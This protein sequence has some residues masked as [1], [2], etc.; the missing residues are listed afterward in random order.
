M[1]A[2]VQRGAPRDFLDLHRLVTSGATTFDECWRIW[3]KKNEGQNREQARAAGPA[4]LTRLETRRPLETIEDLAQREEA[5]TVRT[6]LHEQF[7][8]P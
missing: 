8:K 2:S 5:R 6:W 1:S 3:D 7:F 4:H